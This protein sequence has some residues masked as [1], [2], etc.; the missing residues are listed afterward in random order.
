[1]ADN[2]ELEDFVRSACVGIQKGVTK[3]LELKFPVEF[4]VAVVIQKGVDGALKLLVVDA[5]GNHAKQKISRIKFK[6]GKPL[7]AS[8]GKIHFFRE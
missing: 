3:G 2:K 8:S 5:S 7:E 6:I 4:E 1:M